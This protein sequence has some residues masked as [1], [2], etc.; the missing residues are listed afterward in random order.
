MTLQVLRSAVDT[1]ELSFT[2]GE[3]PEDIITKLDLKK[4][5]AQ[6]KNEPQPIMLAGIEFFMQDK[7]RR[8]YRF[9]A[10]NKDMIVWL[11]AG[12]N[13]LPSMSVRFLAF[14]LASRGIG[15]LWYEAQQIAAELGL[16]HAR[17]SRVDI[18]RDFQ[19]WV[20]GFEEMRRVTCPSGFRPVYPS[21]DNPQTFQFGKGEVVV[22][23]YD[24]TTEMVVSNKEWMKTIWR[25]CEGY[26]QDSP[27]WRI[28]VQL[29]GQVL[30]D[31]LCKDPEEAFSRIGEM[32]VWGLEWAV[33]HEPSETDS[34]LR[35]LPADEK[36]EKLRDAYREDGRVRR[37]RPMAQL[38]DYD[39]A[40][41]R[42]GGILATCA[43][44]RNK[45]DLHGVTIDAVRD[46]EGQ[47]HLRETDFGTLVESKRRRLG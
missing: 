4:A 19:G 21:A 13:S 11:R 46:F 40:I 9:E 6:E 26:D 28:E 15:T 47:L 8:R 29:R 34:N 18:C 37:V 16:G 7:A 25:T 31:F 35:R 41:W 30:S 3:I 17:L 24:K 33:L 22:R 23:L 32:F 1:A 10:R 36:W 12:R 27:V 38:I 43:A 14:G 42:L 2:S 45:D 39:R 20:P 44:I 5:I